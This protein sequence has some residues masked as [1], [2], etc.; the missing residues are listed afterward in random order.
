MGFLK[1]NR[2]SLGRR[3][4]NKH[5]RLVVPKLPFWANI[6]G[7]KISEKCI[8]TGMPRIP[9]HLISDC[10]PVAVLKLE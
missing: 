10:K 6:N 8:N 3:E 4:G 5:G 1:P 9:S 7:L 2:C